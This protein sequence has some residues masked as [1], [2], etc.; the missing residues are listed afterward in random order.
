M[1]DSTIT[2]NSDLILK[3]IPT[4]SMAAKN[5][6][7]NALDLLKAYSEFSGEIGINALVA[8]GELFCDHTFSG[9]DF[10]KGIEKWREAA[11]QGNYCAVKKLL[12][13]LISNPPKRH[14]RS[15]WE[16]AST[17]IHQFEFWR[18][19]IEVHVANCP[20]KRE[21]FSLIEKLTAFINTDVAFADVI[22][23]FFEGDAHHLIA[24]LKILLDKSSKSEIFAASARKLCD[25]ACG[26]DESALVLLMKYYNRLD[27]WVVSPL[28]DQILISLNGAQRYLA[29][30][31]KADALN[32][33]PWEYYQKGAFLGSAT[34]ELKM[35]HLRLTNSQ[36]D[37]ETVEKSLSNLTATLFDKSIT[38]EV[39]SLVKLFIIRCNEARAVDEMVIRACNDT[40]FKDNAMA[41]SIILHYN[42]LGDWITKY[43]SKMTTN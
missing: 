36:T 27:R 11:R 12:E 17:R 35:M 37:L 18:P 6:D 21:F 43:S 29:L 41:Q 39:K 4:Y 30:G 42:K 22:R 10:G 34:C 3:S 31:L 40:A 13:F 15:S 26:G 9:A 7:R 19:I 16:A 32:E 14:L 23:S 20:A 33:A 25:M 2:L 28:I 1:G 5:G 8:V 24:Y 38:A